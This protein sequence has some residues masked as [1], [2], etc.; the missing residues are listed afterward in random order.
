MASP[1][2]GNAWRG[3]AAA[4][5]SSPWV[6]GD[7]SGNNYALVLRRRADNPKINPHYSAIIEFHSIRS[8][9]PIDI[10]M[11]HT[12]IRRPSDDG[13]PAIWGFTSHPFDDSENALLNSDVQYRPSKEKAPGSRRRHGKEKSARSH[14][15]RV[16]R[17][18]ASRRQR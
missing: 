5:W 9:R 2:P 1:N 12:S 16:S 14:R 11:W 7:A 4:N 17:E 10:P 15:F 13:V 8:V 18:P 3:A 6:V